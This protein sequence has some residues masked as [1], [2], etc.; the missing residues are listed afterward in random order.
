MDKWKSKRDEYLLEGTRPAR[1]VLFLEIFGPWYRDKRTRDE[2]LVRRFL[3][4]L[5][6][7]EVGFE[8]EFNKDPRNIDEAV[9]SQ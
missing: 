4:G 8:V 2:D 9:F 5:Y 7:E 1:R 3:D 6:D